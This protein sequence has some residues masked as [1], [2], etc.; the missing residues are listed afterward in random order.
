[1]TFCATLQ[2]TNLVSSQKQENK[3]SV[4]KENTNLFSTV[5]FWGYQKRVQE[6]HTKCHNKKSISKGIAVKPSM[7]NSASRKNTTSLYYIL[8]K[9]SSE[10]MPITSALNEQPSSP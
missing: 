3:I 8:I 4:S 7:V 9:R 1:M 10:A 2:C 5:K 6:D